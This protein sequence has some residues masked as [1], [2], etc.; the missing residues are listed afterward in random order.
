MAHASR[1]DLDHQFS[2]CFASHQRTLCILNA[3]RSE[4][5]LLEVQL[6]G[7]VRDKVEELF[8]VC[9]DHFG[10]D[11]VIC[12]AGVEIVISILVYDR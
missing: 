4:E 9:C 11:E 6:K 3:L 12:C 2:H 1:R 10:F 7:P 8:A 5:V